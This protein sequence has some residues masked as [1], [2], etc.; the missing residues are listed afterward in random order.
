MI[1]LSL[2][3]HI[4]WCVKKCPYC[5]FNSH[6]DNDIDEARYVDALL[7]DL[8]LELDTSQN[9]QIETIFIGGGTPSLF[10][11][12]AIERLM[13][14][15]SSQLSLVDDAEITLEANPGTIDA[16]NFK[17]YRAAGINRLSI[18]AQ[19]FNNEKLVAL[20]RIHQREAIFDGF[21][22]ARD[23][24]F[25]NVNLDLMFGL[26]KQTLDEAL[27]DLKE[28]IA[29]SPEHISWYQLTIEPNTLFNV[30]TPV[31][32]DDDSIW[33]IQEAGQ[34]LLA[35][36]GYF[37]YEIS[38]YSQK[39]YR[40]KHNLNYWEFGDYLA[41]G[42]GAHAKTTDT[43]G[44]IT[45]RWKKRKPQD[46]MDAMDEMS[47]VANSNELVKDD[48]AVEFMLNALR[49]VEGVEVGLFEA[50]TELV[51]SDIE[52]T[53]IKLRCDGLLVDDIKRLTTTKK[54]LLFLNN[55]IARF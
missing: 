37:Q 22:K 28:A 31:L 50:R 55:V 3:V 25:N 6:V 1:P 53:L 30:Q 15:L 35:E 17:A 9:R 39:G 51:L 16:D 8:A 14:G 20:G 34:A 11:G 27:Q 40:S 36:S 44:H 47:F 43:D 41:I 49:L 10:S 4:P 26:P 32:P 2:Y 45:R 5:D 52:D 46:Y 18:G 33:E 29:L 13:E 19:S 54:G 42:A 7:Q 23:A 24:G 48:L 12:D 38:A 21:N